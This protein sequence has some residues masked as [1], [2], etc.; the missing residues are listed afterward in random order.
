MLTRHHGRL[1]GSGR[2]LAICPTGPQDRASPRR[3][4]RGR[5]RHPPRP[6]PRG[7]EPKRGPAAGTPDGT[8]TPAT[9]TLHGGD[10][11]ARRYR[12][13]VCGRLDE[14]GREAFGEFDIT[15]DSTNTALTG[16]L[17]QAALHGTLN[18]I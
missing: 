11:R 15:P 13:I 6:A 8:G 2:T 10:M 12:I 9:R 3:V 5:G 16:D 1:P 7:P 14:V 17:D 18:R 4:L